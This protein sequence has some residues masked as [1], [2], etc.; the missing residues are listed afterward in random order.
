MDTIGKKC[1][2]G[3]F[4]AILGIG[5]G[6]LVAFRVRDIDNMIYYCIGGAI[7][8]GIAA[9]FGADRFWEN[10]RRD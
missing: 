2:H 3:F 1:L 9:F 7:F 6:F 5:V 8:I 4:G 10:L